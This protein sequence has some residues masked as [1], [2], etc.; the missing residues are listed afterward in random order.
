MPEKKI[1]PVFGANF[2]TFSKIGMESAEQVPFSSS[3]FHFYAGKTDLP[4]F[5]AD[6]AVFSKIGM[7]DPPHGPAH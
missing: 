1:Y 5:G 4:L 3:I 7:E 6:F 2:A